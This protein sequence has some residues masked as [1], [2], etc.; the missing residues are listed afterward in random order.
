YGV[1]EHDARSDQIH[2]VH[3]KHLG[4]V[5]RPPEASQQRGEVANDPSDAVREVPQLPAVLVADLLDGGRGGA[6]H[7]EAA[8]A[9]FPHPPRPLLGEELELVRVLPAQEATDEVA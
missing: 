6:A 3:I 4:D 9:P 7:L 5:V 8:A 2:G 1:D